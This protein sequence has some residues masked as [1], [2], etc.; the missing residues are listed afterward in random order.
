MR[1][2]TTLALLLWF[3]LQ[4]PPSSASAADVFLE[5]SRFGFKKITIVILPLE[6]I[7]GH[8]EEAS[9]LENVLLADLDRS[10]YFKAVK[11]SNFSFLQEQE[12]EPGLSTMA[13]A[14]KAG[15]Q[16]L[17]QSKLKTGKEE[18]VLESTAYDTVKKEETIKF[19]IFG[20]ERLIR[21]MAHRLSD[22]LTM[23]FTGEKG[24]AQTKIA[25]VS[26]LSGTK[27]IYVMDYDGANKKKV[28]SDRSI[29][30]SPQWSF[31]GAS[32]AYTSYKNG[33]P[34][35]FLLDVKTWSKKEIIS[36][37]ALNFSAKWS[38]HEK[39]IAFATT[40]DGNSEIYISNSEG[41]ELKRLTFNAGDDF[42]PDWSPTGK[43]LAFT[44]DRGGNPQIYIMN[45][46]GT[47]VSRL[48]FEGN[49]NTSPVWSPKG[50][51]IAYTCRNKEKRFKI[52]ADRADGQ[53]TIAITRGG[54]WND[55]S[56]SWALNGRELTFSSN[57][58]NKNQIFSIHL[59]G[60][61][62]RPLTTDLANNTSPSWSKK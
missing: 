2:R 12:K 61:N 19:K 3:F 49:Y 53:E 30:V 4:T 42:S 29:V 25:Y 45:R 41:K 58:A 21:K 43:Q 44:S 27:E 46:D 57:R 47:N 23:H 34:N 22:K 18:W 26:D 6:R 60:T 36:F 15:I 51:W 17:V 38:P 31:D 56:P 28:T 48:T 9:I 50:D 40:K 14:A 52:C 10:H 24:I 54:P 5:T 16:T 20:G 55:E 59:D 39:K 62:L 1:K 37:P 7:S 32:I 35:I 33:N 13:K 11:A 8:E